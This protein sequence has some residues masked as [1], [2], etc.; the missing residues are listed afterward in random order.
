[1][2]NMKNALQFLKDVHRE[3]EAKE[4]WI[5]AF[6]GNHPDTSRHF[7]MLSVSVP[8][9]TAI[10]PT[11][12]LTLG[13]NRGRDAV[14][15]KR[16]LPGSLVCASDLSI[17]HL[18]PL[19]DHQY[20]DEIKAVDAEAIALDDD[21]VDVVFA[22][23]AFHHW[24]RPMLG[25]YECL[26]VAKKAVVLI[27]PQDYPRSESRRIGT[28]PSESD[29]LSDY[30]TIGN[31]KYLLST[32]EIMKAAWALYLPAVLLKG[33]ND[34]YHLHINQSEYNREE[35]RLTTLG[36]EDKRFH[37]LMCVIIIKDLAGLNLTE[38]SRNYHVFERPSGNAAFSL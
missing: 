12:V 13:D 7:R 30:E 31:F 23:E 16:H 22:K 3:K 14:F 28:Y 19:M 17:Q 11:R 10:T 36:E 25:L 15:I 1:M 29:Y 6:D 9:L 34:P 37:N 4:F 32:R 26:R 8:F 20:I 2:K 27:E 24:Q 5:G 38:L 33:L 21:E 18:E 35:A